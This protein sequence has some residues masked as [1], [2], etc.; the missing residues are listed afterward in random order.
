LY[1]YTLRSFGLTNALAY[2][3]DLMNKDIMG[4]LDK[5]IVMFT[6]SILVYSKSKKEQE[7]HLD[8]V[9]QKLRG[10]RLYVSYCLS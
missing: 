7:E 6:N 8:L 3:M 5:F 9:L 1:E 4:S 2:Y 10:H